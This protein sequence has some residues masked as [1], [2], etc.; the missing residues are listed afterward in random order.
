MK[1]RT[2]KDYGFPQKRYPEF[3][4]VLMKGREI[5]DKPLA[6]PI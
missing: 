6:S 2:G 4:E 3:Y 1:S 5:T